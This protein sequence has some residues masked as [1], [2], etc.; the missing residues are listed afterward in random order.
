MRAVELNHVRG[1]GYKL[2]FIDEDSV[3]VH[4]LFVDITD[5][6]SWLALA[7]M[8]NEWVNG[9]P[10]GNVKLPRSKDLGTYK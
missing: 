9:D 10:K 2:D 3:P 1:V 8:I 6:S 7:T 5:K 4:Y